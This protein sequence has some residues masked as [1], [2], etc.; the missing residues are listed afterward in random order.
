MTAATQSASPRL[1]QYP[2]PSRKAIISAICASDSMTAA[3]APIEPVHSSQVGAARKV[4]L[5]TP[6]C[7]QTEL[8]SRKTGYIA[9]AIPDQYPLMAESQTA[10]SSAWGHRMM[11]PLSVTLPSESQTAGS[12]AW[13]HRMAT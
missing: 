8:A 10:G 7:E 1:P 2:S 5:Q 12:S 3:T 13:G 6:S 11:I 9:V 4:L